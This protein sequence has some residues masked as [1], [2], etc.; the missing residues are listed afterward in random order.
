VEGKYIWLAQGGGATRFDRY[1]ITT[2]MWDYGLLFSPQTEV[3]NTGAMYTY[4]GT[5]RIYFTIA[6]VTCRVFALNLPTM[7]IDACGT[8][9]YSDS[10]AITGN[11]MEL[12]KTADGLPFLYLMRHTAQEMWR[13][14]VYW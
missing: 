3:L 6:G 7:T 8:H 1:D 5:D 14:L 11:R 9:P 4:D 10:T 12:I 2:E 13:T